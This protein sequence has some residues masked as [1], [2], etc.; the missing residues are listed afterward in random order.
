VLGT[1]GTPVTLGTRALNRALL[2]R[3]LLLHRR[4]L[5]AAEAT[6]HLVGMQAQLPLDPYVGLWTRLDGFRPDELA[7]LI[8]Q[9][10]AVRAPL[11]RATIHLVTD[12]D[13]VV[14]RPVVQAVLERVLYVNSPYGRRIEGVDV[15]ELVAAGRDL[16]E[17]RPRTRAELGRLL[18]ERWPGHDA[19]SLAYA[20][21]Y[22]VPLVQVP[23]RGIWGAAGRAVW[24]TAETWLGRPL[25]A[26]PSPDRTVMRYLAAFGP[27]TA[28][29]AQTWSGLT[30]LREVTERLR[31]NL[32]TFRDERGRELFD[33]PDAPLP[34]PDTPAPPRFLPV[35]DN[36]FLGHADRTRIGKE[37]HRRRL[38]RSNRDVRTL[39]VDGFVRGTWNITRHRDR[40][41]LVIEP[42][43]RLSRKDRDSVTAEGSE[44]LAFAA[45]DAETRD[46]RF[47]A[48]P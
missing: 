1:R 47:A 16:L 13:L 22:L 4:K 10:Q 9:R 30:G 12:R 24:T 3:Q 32:R 25:E 23:P 7:R 5:S 48:S 43:E 27:A 21:T 20:I 6:E 8:T 11:M 15:Q 41:T 31:P 40:A 45:G 18:G 19:G 34:D 17:E 14:L 28:M 35:Y 36:T 33:V 37:E 29:D 42:L 44:L 39:L 38:M 2:E 26:D 46:V